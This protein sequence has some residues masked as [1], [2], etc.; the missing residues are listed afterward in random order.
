[1]TVTVG[2][3][4]GE[5]RDAFVSAV[6]ASR[7]LHH[8]WINPA[9]SAPRF[10]EWLEHLR[11]DDQEA[12]LLRHGSCG[13]LVG[14]ISVGNI[15]RRAFQS[16]H[17]GNGAF[18]S[19]A[20][21]GFMTRGVEMVIG[22]AFEELGLHRLEANIQPSNERSLALVRRLGFE[23]EGFSPGYLMV[24]SDWQDHERWAIRA[25]VWKTAGADERVVPRSRR[26][27]GSGRS[28]LP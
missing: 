16:A 25:E 9:D 5:D 4:S 17:L 3:V 19:H 27:T 22:V 15:V 26:A 11:R 8:P 1:V 10:E 12:Y 6:R 24:D 21:R 20:G 13:D 2:P 7:H 14:Y 23:R 28:C 18:S